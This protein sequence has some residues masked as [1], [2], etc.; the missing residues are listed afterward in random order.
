M[1][2][3]NLLRKTILFTADGLNKIFRKTT[4]SRL[5]RFRT[6]EIVMDIGNQIN[7]PSGVSTVIRCMVRISMNV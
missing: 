3:M 7:L 2:T 4:I 5:C 6:N 1:N